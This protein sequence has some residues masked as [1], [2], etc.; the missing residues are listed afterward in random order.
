MQGQRL[1]DSKIIYPSNALS[2]NRALK[3]NLDNKKKIVSSI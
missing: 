1:K 3:S 2:L